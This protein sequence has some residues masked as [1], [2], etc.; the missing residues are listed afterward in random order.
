MP[1]GALLVARNITTDYLF[2]RPWKMD[3]EFF[4]EEFSSGGHSLSQG[5]FAAA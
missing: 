3:A 1:L 4:S 5:A 2:D